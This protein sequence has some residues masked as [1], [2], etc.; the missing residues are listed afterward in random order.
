ME[1]LDQLL[2]ESTKA[3]KHKATEVLLSNKEILHIL[4]LTLVQATQK[5]VSQVE[6]FLKL[7]S[8]IQ[9][10][11]LILKFQSE[12][13]KQRQL[14]I[15]NTY[16]KRPSSDLLEIMDKMRDGQDWKPISMVE[17]HTCYTCNNCQSTNS[18]FNGY[19]QILQ[20]KMNR[21]RRQLV[22][23]RKADAQVNELKLY[24]LESKVEKCIECTSIPRN[25]DELL[26]YKSL[27][28]G[29]LPL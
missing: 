5:T 11:A 27:L 9:R 23:M 20:H 17:I 15:D 12:F 19:Y 28:E 3:Y 4:K 7:R 26:E 8:T 13:N 2:E 22:R 16:N 24:T 29:V 18:I 6:Q 21:D 14:Y 10:E 1:D 25:S